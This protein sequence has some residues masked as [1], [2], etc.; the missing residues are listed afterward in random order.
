MFG[1]L[2]W[3]MRSRLRLKKFSEGWVVHFAVDGGLETHGLE[4]EVEELPRAPLRARA[5]LA[6]RLLAGFA[7]EHSGESP[8]HW[9]SGGA[10]ADRGRRRSRR[11]LQPR[12]RPAP[13]L[14]RAP[15]PARPPT[16]SGQA[17]KGDVVTVSSCGLE[18]EGERKVGKGKGGTGLRKGLVA[19]AGGTRNLK[20]R[21]K[22]GALRP[23]PHAPI[24]GW[25]RT[26]WRIGQC[27]HR[28]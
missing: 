16:R 25:R 9:R 15:A 13:S 10:T 23:R 6:P 27:R 5:P 22:A 14:M 19:E 8:D 11:R 4:A 28:P 24:A 20:S 18:S 17:N 7:V 26:L 1:R 3:K 21:G 2:L 12:G